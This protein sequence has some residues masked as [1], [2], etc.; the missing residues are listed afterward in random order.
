MVGKCGIPSCLSQGR[1]RRDQEEHEEKF[2]AVPPSGKRRPETHKHCTANCT[3]KSSCLRLSVESCL[4]PPNVTCP[5][6]VNLPQ[7]LDLISLSPKEA[8]RNC[9]TPPEVFWCISLYGVPTDVTHLQSRIFIHHESFHT[10]AL[11]GHPMPCLLR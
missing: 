9:N 6:R 8:A 11:A 5:P 10:L 1:Q 3:S 2:S 4:Y 7:H